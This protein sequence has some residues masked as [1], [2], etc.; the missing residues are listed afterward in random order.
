MFVCSS[1]RE[2]NRK[3][4]SARSCRKRYSLLGESC[5]CN[6][7]KT[8]NSFTIFHWRAA[9]QPLTQKQASS[10]VTV[11]WGDK[12]H[13]FECLTLPLSLPQILLLSVMPS[14]GMGHLFCQLGSTV[15]IL[16]P[17]SSL[18][19]PSLLDGSERKRSVSCDGM[20]TQ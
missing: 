1:Q 12:H 10:H 11:C 2:E 3:G 19:T 8:K 6:Q 17:F 9:A 16:C 4:E 13:H 20:F 5:A 7:S 15:L 18:C 14:N